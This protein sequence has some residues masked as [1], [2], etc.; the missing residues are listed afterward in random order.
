MDRRLER[1]ARF[2]A[3]PVLGLLMCWGGF[4]GVRTGLRELPADPDISIA[5]MSISMIVCVIGLA[6][7]HDFLDRSFRDW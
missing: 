5:M 1:L 7:V 2:L 3:Q 6:A 4:R